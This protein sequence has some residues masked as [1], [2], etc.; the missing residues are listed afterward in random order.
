MPYRRNK[1]GRSRR[2]RR[3]K[4]EFESQLLDL[5]RVAH[6]REGGKKLRFRAV[7]VVGDQK[8]RVGVGVS[9]GLDVAKAIEK[10]SRLAK[11]NVITVPI[12]GST[13]PHEVRAKYGAARVMLKPQRAG[14]GL[15]AGGTVR[16]ICHLSGIKDIS[17]KV[18]GATGNKINNARAT[19]KALKKLKVLEPGQ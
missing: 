16:I 19:I 14:R 2:D 4:D 10:A 13:I 17:S 9:S 3:E 12:K 11:K 18:L 1:R 5:A 7:M 15:V 8:G 6:T